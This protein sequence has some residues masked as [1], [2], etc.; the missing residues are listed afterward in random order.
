[1]ENEKTKK[2]KEYLRL[3]RNQD[4]NK[5]YELLRKIYK[6]KSKSNKSDE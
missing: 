2:M 4:E 3:K 5:Y 1:M 6:D